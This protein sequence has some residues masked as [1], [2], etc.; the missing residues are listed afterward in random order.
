MT[1]VQTCALPIYNGNSN[2]TIASSA[3]NVAVNVNGS[4]IVSFTTAGIINNMGNATG[5]IG[6]VTVFL[7][8]IAFATGVEAIGQVGNVN[9]AA[10]GIVFLT[11]VQAVGIVGSALVWSQ[12]VDDQ[13]PD[14]QNVF[15]FRIIGNTGTFGGAPFAALPFAGV[16]EIETNDPGISW[17]PVDDEQTT[18]WQ[19]IAA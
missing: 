12:I 8:Q 19:L 1:G 14:W 7:D 2:V 3:G 4:G 15:Y 17:D 18:D 11:G 6:N 5:N 10:D 16:G 9:P 13:T